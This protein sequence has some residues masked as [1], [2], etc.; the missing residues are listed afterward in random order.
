MGFLI[1]TSALID[2]FISRSSSEKIR[3]L[4]RGKE[5]FV[6]S[7]TVYEFNKAKNPD[8][9]I[10]EFLKNCPVLG[11]NVDE[12]KIASMISK[13]LRKNGKAINEMDILIS[14]IAITNRLTVVTKDKDFEEVE[15]VL[16]EFKVKIF[17]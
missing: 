8:S 9:R 4:V 14:A 16:K 2:V 15:N 13:E 7:I 12:A 11:F 17:G 6:S 3:E 5:F 1:D 10:L